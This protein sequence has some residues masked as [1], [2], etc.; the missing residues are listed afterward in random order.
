MV[1]VGLVI[2]H[3]AAGVTLG[4]CVRLVDVDRQAGAAFEA[5]LLLRE[6]SLTWM[7]LAEAALLVVTLL[8]VRAGGYRLVRQDKGVAHCH[9]HQRS[10]AHSPATRI[11]EVSSRVWP[12][13]G[14]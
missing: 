9:P 4:T 2:S 3:L 12:K 1:T 6:I 11:A 7:L 14:R 10:K 5:F 8:V 13:I